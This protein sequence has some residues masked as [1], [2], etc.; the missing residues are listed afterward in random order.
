METL[1]VAVK[2]EQAGGRQ[3]QWQSQSQYTW[4]LGDLEIWRLGFDLLARVHNACISPLLQRSRNLNFWILPDPV[5]GN[6]STENQWRGV[7]YGASRPRR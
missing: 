1:T 5:N 3:G 2:V 7:L 6:A 4:R